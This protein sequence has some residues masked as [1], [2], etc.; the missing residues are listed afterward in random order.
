MDRACPFIPDLF[1]FTLATTPSLKGSASWF[2]KFSHIWQ[3]KISFFFSCHGRRNLV[4]PPGKLT[5]FPPPFINPQNSHAALRLPAAQGFPACSSPRDWAVGLI[6]PAQ[7]KEYHR[8][9]P[10]FD[11]L[12]SL[13]SLSPVSLIHGQSPSSNHI[14]FACPVANCKACQVSSSHGCSL[15]TFRAMYWSLDNIRLDLHQQIAGAGAAVHL[16]VLQD[17]CRNQPA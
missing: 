8:F 15:Y 4:F 5:S 10:A 6:L 1:R 11:F 13:L 12:I 3:H 17:E 2:P 9:I 16:G 14:L 7:P